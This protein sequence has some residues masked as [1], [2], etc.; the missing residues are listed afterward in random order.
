MKEKLRGGSDYPCIWF[1]KMKSLFCMV[2]NWSIFSTMSNYWVDPDLND[3]GDC[4]LLLQSWT[5][6]RFTSME[7]FCAV[8]YWILLENMYSIIMPEN[9][10]PYYWIIYPIIQS[11]VHIGFNKVYLSAMVNSP[12]HCIQWPWKQLTAWQETGVTDVKNDFCQ[13]GHFSLVRQPEK[14]QTLNCL[15]Y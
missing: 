1:I 13:T 12:L 3:E 15:E 4:K 14:D 8:E 10:S 5:T 9:S 6:F 2:S 7:E 11:S